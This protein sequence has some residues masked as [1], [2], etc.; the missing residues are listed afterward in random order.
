MCI[1]LR[2]PKRRAQHFQPKG[3]L[4][5]LVQFRRED[6]I[7]VADA[8]AIRKCALR[9]RSTRVHKM[10]RSARTVAAWALRCPSF[11]YRISP[12][13]YSETVPLLLF[14]GP[15]SSYGNWFGLRCRLLFHL[16]CG[17]LR[18]FTAKAAGKLASIIRV[19]VRVV[20]SPRN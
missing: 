17:T 20:L 12:E 16:R 4:Q 15:H 8:V 19:N 9:K 1:R 10:L 2:R 13:S 18:T 7:A 5:F 6:R 14:R 3:E 11:R